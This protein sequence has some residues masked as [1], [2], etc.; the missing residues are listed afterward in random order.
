MGCCCP[1]YG[2][3]EDTTGMRASDSFG[4]GSRR[5]SGTVGRQRYNIG[6]CWTSGRRMKGEKPTV[7]DH[8]QLCMHSIVSSAHVP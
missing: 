3:A 7:K 6:S 5:W 2:G 8:C 4:L 1:E